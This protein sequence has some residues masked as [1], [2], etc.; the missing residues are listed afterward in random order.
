[1]MKALKESLQYFI[2]SLCEC[3]CVLWRLTAGGRGKHTWTKVEQTNIEGDEGTQGCMC[4]QSFRLAL[5]RCSRCHHTSQNITYVCFKPSPSS[6]CSKEENIGGVCVCY[7]VLCKDKHIKVLPQ[8][9]QSAAFKCK[10][11]SKNTW[12][13]PMY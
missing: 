4:P 8:F 11:R 2:S 12:K 7:K 9:D 6:L 5:S 13:I 1:M 3:V 10:T